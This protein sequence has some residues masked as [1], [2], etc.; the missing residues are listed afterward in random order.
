MKRLIDI[1]IAKDDGTEETLL[2]A[3]PDL[4]VLDDISSSQDDWEEM[5]DLTREEL[6]KKG[7]MKKINA[8]LADVAPPLCVS[9]KIGVIE[10]GKRDPEDA[11]FYI[12]LTKRIRGDFAADQEIMIFLAI[13][14][15]VDQIGKDL[16]EGMKAAEKFLPVVDGDSDRPSIESIGTPPE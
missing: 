3:R 14:M 12:S 8:F 1:V 2:F 16:E 11:D 5:R 6:T 15:T 9:H 10:N 7:M 4:V 13:M